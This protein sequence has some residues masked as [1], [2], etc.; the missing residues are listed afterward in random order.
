MHRDSRTS[1]N[2]DHK[3]I[4]HAKRSLLYHQNWP[5][6]KKG[7][8]DTFDVTMGSYDRAETCELVGLYMLSLLAQK[9][10]NQVGLY[11]DEGITICKAKP[12]QVEKNKQKVQIPQPK[13][14]HWSQ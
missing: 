12:R 6:A 10:K 9:F 4:I 3:I 8:A 14:H 1:A 2:K 13:N 11:C 5:W 7:T